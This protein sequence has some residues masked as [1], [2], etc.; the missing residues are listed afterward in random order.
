MKNFNRHP[1]QQYPENHVRC[2]FE[3]ALQMR[4]DLVD[5]AMEIC[6]RWRQFPH[7]PDC[8]PIAGHIDMRASQPSL[9]NLKHG[10]D[11][12]DSVIGKLKREAGAA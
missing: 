1:F 2:A 10:M 9:Q 6:E 3:A 8:P 5:N 4:G 7:L 12:I 11:R